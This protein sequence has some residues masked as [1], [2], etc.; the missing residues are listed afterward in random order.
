MQTNFYFFVD[1]K[2]DYNLAFWLILFLILFSDLSLLYIYGLITYCGYVFICWFAHFCPTS[3][4]VAKL[5]VRKLI[6]GHKCNPQASKMASKMDMK[7]FHRFN[8]YKRQYIEHKKSLELE[9]R[10]MVKG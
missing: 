6:T 3:W 9:Q 7:E 10:P 2:F 5:L 4:R 1:A 8:T